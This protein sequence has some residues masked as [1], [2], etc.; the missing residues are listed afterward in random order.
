[1]AA[2]SAA[3]QVL[4]KWNVQR[5]VAVIPKAGSEP[6]LRE[7]IEGLFSWSLTWDQKVG[8]VRQAELCKGVRYAVA[9]RRHCPCT[10]LQPCSGSRGRA[11][12]RGGNAH[13]SPWPPCW[14][15]T[16]PPLLPLLVPPLLICRLQA[17]LDA[18]DCGKRFVD[19]AWHTWEDAE[20]GGAAKPSRV[21]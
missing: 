16:R 7:N 14:F 18:I 6:H 19:N 10:P 17:K 2:S 20:E 1:M 13:T 5:G 3:L 12:D 8:L 15:L 11:A 21:L 9:G 4:L